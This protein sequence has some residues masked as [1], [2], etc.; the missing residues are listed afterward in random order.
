MPAVCCEGKQ[1]EVLAKGCVILRHAVDDG[2]QHSRVL[3]RI[4]LPEIANIYPPFVHHDCCH[5]QLV[6]ISNRVCGVVPRP[7]CVGLDKLRKAAWKLGRSLPKTV[8]EDYFELVSRYS[9]AK[10][11]KYTEATYDVLSNGFDAKRHSLIKA[12]V[13]AER[14]DGF[15]KVNPDPRMIQFRDARFCV[16]VSRFLKPIEEHLYQMKG[17]SRGVPLTRNVAKGLNQGERAILLQRKMQEFDDPVVVSLD[18][19]RFDKHVDEEMLRLEHLV[20]SIS[21]PSEEFKMLLRLQLRNTCFSTRGIKYRTRGKRMSGDMNTALG[22]CVI[23]L[24]MLLAYM[25]WCAKWDC[26]DDGDDVLVILEFKDL[27]R[28]KATVKA[29]FLEFGMVVKVENIARSLSTVVFCQSRVV[30]G[31]NFTKFVR[32]PIKVMSCALSGVRYYNVPNARASLLYSI[33]TCELVLSLGVPV[34]Q[35]FALAI[36]RNATGG[37]LNVNMVGDISVR[38][39]RELRTTPFSLNNVQPME[40]T[41]EARDSF[42]EA[43]GWDVE[44]Q[45]LVEKALKVWSFDIRGLCEI[46]EEWSKDW[47]YTNEVRSEWYPLGGLN[48]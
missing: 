21:N 9:G 23:M 45:H 10:A 29:C 41:E 4:A 43:F 18:A 34:L 7:S 26:L 47:Q 24:M 27:E 38:M 2:C 12:F 40:V 30:V 28:F 44:Y 32:D 33:G 6:A 17:V 25:T 15:S 8:E 46:P 42:A 35:E 3:V 31:R 13:K 39:G 16:E 37:K 48:D 14:T 20:Y 5:N 22:N 19:S 11:L 36:R 1:P